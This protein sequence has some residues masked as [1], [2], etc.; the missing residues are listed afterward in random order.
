M[1]VGQENIQIGLTL[2]LKGAFRAVEELCF[3]R[4]NGM[5]KTIL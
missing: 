1:C 2:I 5:I 3:G 4:I